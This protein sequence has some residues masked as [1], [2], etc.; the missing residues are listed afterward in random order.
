MSNDTAATTPSEAMAASNYNCEKSAG[1][2]PC[3]DLLGEGACCFMAKVDSIPADRTDAQK[4]EDLLEATK[5]WPTAEGEENN[6][7]L[8]ANNIKYYIK[9]DENQVWSQYYN[10][11]NMKGY[12]VGAAKLASAA[13]AAA[14]VIFATSF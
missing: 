14:A 8:D 2:Q 7:C 12:C 10:G 9:E 5:G 13:S 11:I 1:D 6:F 4:A 3:I